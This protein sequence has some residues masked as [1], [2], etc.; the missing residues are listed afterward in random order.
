MKI[1]LLS[2]GEGVPLTYNSWSFPDG[3]PHIIL[4]RSVHNEIVRITVRLTSLEELFDLLLVR[5]ILKRNNNVIHL[6][7]RYLMGARMDRPIDDCQPF[8][9][10]VITDMLQGFAS[11]QILDAHSQVAVDLLD[12][13]NLYPYHEV[14]DLL[15]DFDPTNTAIVVPDKGAHARVQALIGGTG[16]TRIVLCHKERDLA[17]GKLYGFA[18]EDSSRIR[19]ECVIIDDICD[20]GR[21]FV[22]LA[23]LLRAAGAKYITLFV[24]HG[25]FSKGRSLEGIDAVYSTDS[26][27]KESVGD[28]LP[29][30]GCDNDSSNRSQHVNAGCQWTVDDQQPGGT[31]RPNPAQPIIK[32]Y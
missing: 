11:V 25:I 19:D 10:K 29:C 1:E 12:A 31:G 5:D 6:S 23:S 24:T 17:T 8:T 9:L 15:R 4:G 30:W 22:G 16:H 21:T 14:R 27:Q 13:A 28:A 26:Y 7:I 2:R 18:I 32:S 3:Q 20:G